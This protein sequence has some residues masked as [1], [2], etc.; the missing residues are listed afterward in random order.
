[1][2]LFSCYRFMFMVLFCFDVIGFVAAFKSWV[3]LLGASP[4][5]VR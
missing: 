2:F 4:R 3:V 5:G 1:M